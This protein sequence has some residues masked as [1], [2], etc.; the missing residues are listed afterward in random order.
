MNKPL[1]A[2]VLV[3]VLALGAFIGLDRAPAPQATPVVVVAAPKPA[4]PA[5][6]KPVLSPTQKVVDG[7]ASTASKVADAAVN[8][9]ATVATGAAQAVKQ[10]VSDAVG[11]ATDS[12]INTSPPPGSNSAAPTA[13]AVAAAA[14]MSWS[15]ATLSLDQI[16]SRIASADIPETTRQKVMIAFDDAKGDPVK[17]QS[18]L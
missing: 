3:A 9:T 2:A 6:P 11:A 17:L 5:T 13:Q 4:M 16:K 10:A 12:A 15:V 7:A 8:V 14:K 1:V 18:V